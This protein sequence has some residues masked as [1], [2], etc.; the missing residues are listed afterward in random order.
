VIVEAVKQAEGD[1]YIGDDPSLRSGQASAMV[2]GYNGHGLIV[3]MYETSHAGTRATI[4]FGFP[5]EAVFETDLMENLLGKLLL[6][7]NAV[8]LEFK[9]FE[10]KTIKIR[11]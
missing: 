1:G 2:V 6:E 4:K 7:E 5:V 8:K 3:R 11:F 9:P 10:I